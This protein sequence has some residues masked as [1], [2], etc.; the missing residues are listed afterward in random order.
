MKRGSLFLIPLVLVLWV[1]NG[2]RAA[3][4]FYYSIT[5]KGKLIGYAM[6]ESERVV[7][8]AEELMCIRSETHLKVAMLGKAR[9]TLLTSETLV[10]PKSAKP[11]RYTVTDTTNELV[12]HTD[13]EFREGVVRTCTYRDGEKKPKPTETKLP[14]E[15]LLLGGNN[16]GHWR[17]LCAG[18]AASKQGTVRVPVF[19]PEAAKL[20][21]YELVRGNS[22]EV[23]VLGKPRRSVVWR[24]VKENINVFVDA[25]TGE[26]MGMELPAQQA[27]ILLADETVSKLAQQAGAQEVLAEHFVQ[28]DV[29]FDDWQ[30]ITFLKAQIDA[31][32][33]GTG[34]A[35]DI[36][37]L[38]TPMQEFTGKK[39]GA[40]VSGTFTIRTR[41]YEGKDS[42]P[43]PGSPDKKLTAWVGPSECI[44]CDHPAIVAKAQ[45]LAK[46]AASRWE[47]VLRVA[48]WV[49]KEVSY[50]IAD[51]PSARLAL[52]T[53]KGDCGPHATLTVALLR[54]VGI[55][56]RL[57]GG[58]LYAPTFGGCFAQHAW[59]EVH[60]G[61][62]GWVAL[63]PTIG[64]HGKLCA[65]H[66]KMFEG[67]G[68]V[69]P[70]TVHVV[71][72][73][74][75]NRPAATT[76]PAEARPLPWNL[77]ERYV[78]RY[79]RGDTDIGSEAF[80]LTKIK[81]DGK[82]GYEMKSDV[83]L[84]I[85]GTTLKSTARMTVT[86]NV[87]PLSFRRE[88]NAA[89]QDYTIE[90]TFR[91]DEVTEK[92][93][94]AKELARQIKISPGTYC[95]DNNLLASW[96]LL[97]SQLRFE[98]D[99]DLELRAFHPSSLQVMSITFKPIRRTPLTVAGKT[100]ECWEC[101]VL[102]IKNTFW[103]TD[104][105]RFI[106]AQQGKLTMELGEE[107]K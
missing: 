38:T 101:E 19:M 49:T 31:D 18:L 44:E 26:F 81:L 98:K 84:R 23:N 58:L 75:P 61:E 17:L 65:T 46:G 50:T 56:A 34:V 48:K 28:S 107:S 63:D 76:K 95:F 72:F 55:P 67:M 27:R 10:Q 106:K 11:V 25:Q 30:K 94:G 88:L 104:A 41:A 37:V 12:Q 7:R 47:A 22:E 89:G 52:E 103:I 92:I 100:T 85:A 57:V 14:P 83:D 6:V 33:I 13:C 59:C 62:T 54:A 102:P 16:F 1:P 15:T 69:V 5:L 82:D 80:T 2:A 24:L 32:L 66:I 105:G 3:D 97:C 35:D 79:K 91:E 9:R 42:P 73:Q 8:D 74:P 40:H 68:G 60:M 43:F 21:T 51:S 36:R 78:V 53:R 99:K 77:G 29:L 90:C 71:A 64:E 93:T 39:D 20:E 86:G 45:E 87:Q 70:K 96:V 4:R